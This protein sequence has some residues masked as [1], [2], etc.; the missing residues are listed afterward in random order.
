MADKQYLELLEHILK[1]GTV[2]EDRTGTGTK[3][4]FGYMMRF[5]LSKGFPLLT[6]KKVIM[7][8][9]SSEL[10]WFI[11]G[12]TNIRYLLQHNNHIW[13]DWCFQ[14][15]VESDEYKALGKPDMTDFAH[16][17]Q[18]D[19]EFDE[20][21]QKELK[22][23][24]ERI[25]NDD[26]FCEK[27]GDIGSSGAY[28]ANWRSFAGPNGK[29]IDQLKNV[30]QQIKNNPDSRRLLVNAWNPAE[31]DNALLPPCHYSFQFYVADGK[32]SCLWNM[33]S[34]DVFLG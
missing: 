6:T 7:R 12:D 20:V 32:L 4:I 19:P 33:R 16:R 34:N 23:F 10:L 28:G 24:C 27:Y 15:W 13:D 30:I 25:L 2:K 9:I 26:E 21:Y 11:K 5:D 3:S 1:N 14:K 18:K 17:A 8:L 31:V 29:R 22:E